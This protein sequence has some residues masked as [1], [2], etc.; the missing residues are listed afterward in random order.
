MSSKGTAQ[1][2]FTTIEAVVALAIAGLTFVAFLE[3]ITLGLRHLDRANAQARTAIVL[4]S[5]LAQQ[6]NQRDAAA[7]PS[8]A[9]EHLAID[10]PDVIIESTPH[11]R[12]AGARWITVRSKDGGVSITTF[13]MDGTR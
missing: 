2:G 4:L 9:R 8:T 6:D 1:S 7:L 5:T 12:L 3:G 13:R 11:K 10:G